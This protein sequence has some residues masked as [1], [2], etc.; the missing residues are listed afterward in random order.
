M[1]EPSKT[2]RDLELSIRSLLP[3]ELNVGHSLTSQ[4]STTAAV[5]L[6]GLFTGYVWGRLRGRRSRSRRAR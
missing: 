2:R 5:G 6:G 1:T 3:D 4:T